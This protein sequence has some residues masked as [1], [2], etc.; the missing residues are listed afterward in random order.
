MIYGVGCG[1]SAAWW[2]NQHNKHHATPQKLKHDVDLDTGLALMDN[3]K[4]QLALL[5]R[6]RD[7]L[8]LSEK[9]FDLPAT[10]F[11]DLYTIKASLE[12]LDVLYSLYAEEQEAVKKWSNTLWSELEVQTLSRLGVQVSKGF[13]IIYVQQNW[14][15]DFSTPTA[16]LHLTTRQVELRR[17]NP[18]RHRADE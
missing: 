9:L 7:Q 10:S 16:L 12:R 5:S 17:W 11:T 8:T 18:K 4:N 14:P 15:V 13:V 6:E 3:Y 1:M 2:R